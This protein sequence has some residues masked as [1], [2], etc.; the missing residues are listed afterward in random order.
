MDRSKFSIDN[1]CKRVYCDGLRTYNIDM[2]IHELYWNKKD[3]DKYHISH[4][5][6]I[7]NI[8]RK[9]SIEDINKLL[10]LERHY[11]FRSYLNGNKALMSAILVN[12]QFSLYD[13]LINK[14]N[15]IN[16]KID[17]MIIFFKLI[18]LDFNSIPRRELESIRSILKKLKYKF[19]DAN[20]F[21]NKWWNTFTNKYEDC[22]SIA[23]TKE[24]FT[25]PI[26]FNKIIYNYGI[27]FYEDYLK[28][29][30]ANFHEFANW[31]YCPS[32]NKYN[33]NVDIQFIFKI[34]TFYL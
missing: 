23:R 31:E 12:S 7:I 15:N 22:L 19:S 28:D 13:Y 17:T 24:W 21:N 3:T 33:N 30:G 34:Q 32:F 20:M 18:N 2:L 16:V 9:L 6:K 1:L 26:N 14:T 5:Y 4:Q 11:D 10:I 27:N 25:L 29:T 8:L